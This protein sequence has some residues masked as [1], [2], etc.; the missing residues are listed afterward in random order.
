MLIP[1][2]GGSRLYEFD[3]INRDHAMVYRNESR[4]LDQLVLSMDGAVLHEMG[5]FSVSY[6]WPAG[7]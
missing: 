5:G 6:D 4:P 1:L 7:C 2:F 3:S